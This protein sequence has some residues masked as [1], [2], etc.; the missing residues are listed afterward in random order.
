MRHMVRASGIIEI[1]IRKRA[2]YIF[3][4]TGDTKREKESESEKGGRR[5]C[6]VERLGVSDLSECAVLFAVIFWCITV[7]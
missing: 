5:I 6:E 3:A 1:V 4:L 7:V 2:L